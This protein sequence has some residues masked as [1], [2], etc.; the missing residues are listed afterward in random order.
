ME[1]SPILLRSFIGLL[2]QPWMADD[3]D[4]DDDCGAVSEMSG[5]RNRKPRR[6]P[7]RVPLY[8]PQIPHELPR[9]RTRAAAMGSRRLSA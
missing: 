4:D 2:C 3:D 6:K 9:N 8:E 5:R 7:A 1:P